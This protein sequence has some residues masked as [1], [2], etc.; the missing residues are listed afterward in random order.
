MSN[1]K[2]IL[3]EYEGEFNPNGWAQ[4]EKRLP[5]PTFMQRFG[6]FIVGGAAG[7]LVIAGVL[8]AVLWN[9]DDEKTLPDEPI[10]QA[11]ISDAVQ[12]DNGDENVISVTDPT[13][14][15]NTEI[16]ATKQATTTIEVAE[17]KNTE[18]AEMNIVTSESV[19]QT[20][21]SASNEKQDVAS[22]SQD[23]QPKQAPKTISEPSFS[24]SCDKR[25]TP[26]IAKFSAVGVEAD[27][28]VVWDFGNGK[29]GNGNNATCEYRKKGTFTPSASL[30]RGGKLQKKTTLNAITIG[31]T[32]VVDFSW[33]STDNTYTFY[34]GR[35]VD[36]AYKWEIDGK[37]FTDKSVEHEF[38]RSGDYPIKLVLTDGECSAEA[39]KSV[40]VVIS[41]VYFVPNAFT[42]DSDGVN[43][44][45]GPIGEDLN[46]KTYSF[47]ITNSRGDAVFTST[48]PA[49]QWNGKINNV[50]PDVESGV[51]Y[52]IIKTV[53]RYGNSQTRKGTVNVMR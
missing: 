15:P 37:S 28:E 6:K 40:K 50:G 21:P 42:P 17:T 18:I 8:V 31:E 51:Y 12:N 30:Y 10:A 46:F 2:K 32:P 47:G 36:L 9:N 23:N 34:T 16:S 5:K 13:A 52:W 24:V 45:F 20:E 3:S 35:T 27:C 48:D 29:Q 22:K 43:S 49:V 11:E 44:T 14:I 7:A 4:L 33:R 53:D 26:A 39:T 19:S 41:H 25:C 38:V 1:L